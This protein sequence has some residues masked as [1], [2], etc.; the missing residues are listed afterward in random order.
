MPARTD[1]DVRVLP[2]GA[3]APP[4]DLVSAEAQPLLLTLGLYALAFLLPAW[5][6]LS[7]TV[8]IPWDA[9]SQF[10]PQL[11]FLARSLAT[12][13]SP[14]W[15]PN[16]FAGWPQINDPQSLI[17]SPLHFLL[18]Y[19][20]SAPSALAF[21]RVTF[22]LLFLGGVGII[23]FFRDRGWHPAGALVAAMAF[24]FGGAANARLQHTIQIISLC[25]LALALWLLARTLDRGSWRLGLAAGVFG[26]LL[27]V[28]R[29]H[30]ALLS[31][32]VLGGYVAFHWITSPR[33]GVRASLKPLAAAGATGL[34][35]AA[36]PVIMTALLAARSNRPEIGYAVAGHGSLHPAD[37]LLL[38]FAD[39]FHAMAPNI[40]WWG[41][42]GPRWHAAFGSTDLYTSKNMGLLYAG[43]VPLVALVSFGLVRGHAWAREI[44]F[45]TIAASATAQPTS[46]GTMAIS[47]ARC[48]R[49]GLPTRPASQQCTR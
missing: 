5:P 38:A 14:F 23:L 43:A 19:F 47:T 48:R 8:T 30:V 15:T 45:F 27:A 34:V 21:D 22:A 41:P 26:G 9:E 3:V 49:V 10:R 44:R 18:A 24:A 37:L 32:Y 42:P 11:S 6:W 4:A 1:T 36:V 35:I 2:R 28:D 31:L 33:G 39:L 7:G 13:Q 40:D 17:F 25:Y 29:D 16:V 12:G 46:T 20:D